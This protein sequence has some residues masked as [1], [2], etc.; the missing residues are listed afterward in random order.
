MKMWFLRGKE[1]IKDKI[2]ELLSLHPVFLH[3]CHFVS[4][5]SINVH[6]I[7][8]FHALGKLARLLLAF[9][10]QKNWKQ[11]T[12]F[13][14]KDCKNG[15][16]VNKASNNEEIKAV[17]G[18]RALSALALLMSHKSV[19]LMYNPYINRTH[20]MKVKQPKSS[21]YYKF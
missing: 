1:T 19:A 6:C 5:Y 3:S 4:N 12:D 18:I 10:I 11:L 21:F 9:A 20:T 2:A 13:D 14:N 17:H 16:A 8:L 15:S 7:I